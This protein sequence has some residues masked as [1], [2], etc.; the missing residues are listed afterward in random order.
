VTRKNEHISYRKFHRDSLVNENNGLQF[1][2]WQ[3][4][5]E[6]VKKADKTMLPIAL[7]LL[8]KQGKLPLN[9]ADQ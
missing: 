8:R 9:T 5:F 6:G 3:H 4:G 7:S 1:M 2:M